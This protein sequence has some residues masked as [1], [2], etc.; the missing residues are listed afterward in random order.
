VSKTIR[1]RKAWNNESYGSDSVLALT[2]Y[3]VAPHMIVHNDKPTITFVNESGLIEVR[4][5]NGTSSWDLIGST[6][7]PT[8]TPS[9]VQLAVNSDDD[10]FLAYLDS[11]NH[12]AHILRS[13]GVHLLGLK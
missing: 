4:K 1:F 6:I 13:N 2:N 3:P 10:L 5:F 11:T 12:K 8:G 7:A 9:F